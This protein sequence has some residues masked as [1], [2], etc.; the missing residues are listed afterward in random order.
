MT[1][2]RPPRT[3]SIVG[4]RIR[5]SRA[6]V[7]LTQEQLA[8]RANIDRVTIAKIESG[9]R[10]RAALSSLEALAPILG[11]SVDYLRGEMRVSPIEPQIQDYLRHEYA[12]IDQPTPEE[13][14]WFRA[15][16]SVFWRGFPS[17]PESIHELIRLHRKSTT[18]L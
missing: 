6:R 18:K 3:P 13:I 9:E 4:I 17:N 7:D 11:V 15:Q 1:K 5:E 12:K 8:E 14:D 2:H 16:D 10:Q